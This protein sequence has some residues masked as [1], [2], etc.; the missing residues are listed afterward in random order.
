[1]SRLRIILAGILV[2]AGLGTLHAAP[3]LSPVGKPRVLV[4]LVE[5]QDLTFT[6]PDPAGS[7]E[8]MLNQE[9]YREFGG[10]GSVRDYFN[11]N[12]QGL[13]V[14]SFEVVGP[15][16]LSKPVSAYGKDVYSGGVRKGDVAPELALSEACALV[17][18]QVNF[19]RYD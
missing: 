16:R 2:L 5:F 14:P 7:F 8:R 13:F 4:L 11:D 18:G 17:D 19:A 9:G 10:T 1:M 15:V 3:A 12:S 6:V